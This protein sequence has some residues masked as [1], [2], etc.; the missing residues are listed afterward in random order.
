MTIDWNFLKFL[1]NLGIV[2]GYTSSL[3]DI[4]LRKFFSR[5]LV[6]QF[7]SAENSPRN[8][9]IKN[10]SFFNGNFWVRLYKLQLGWGST[11]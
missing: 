8:I 10:F 11:S 5:S 2:S 6:F 3:Y 9:D 7:I 1:C 4:E